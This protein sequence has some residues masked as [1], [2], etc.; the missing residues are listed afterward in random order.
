MSDT[1]YTDASVY[2]CPDG[3][4]HIHIVVGDESIT[5]QAENVAEWVKKLWEAKQVAESD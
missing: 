4:P 5:V 3:D 1:N 2:P